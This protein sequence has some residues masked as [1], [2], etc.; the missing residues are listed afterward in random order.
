MLAV[1]ATILFA[2]ALLFNLTS[3]RPGSISVLDL[4]LAGLLLFA[5]HFAVWRSAWRGRR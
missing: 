3:T 2:L 5:L 1:I 4:E